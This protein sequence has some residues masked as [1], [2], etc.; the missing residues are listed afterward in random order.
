[1]FVCSLTSDRR[2]VRGV[3]SSFSRSLG[4]RG[5]ILDGGIVPNQKSVHPEKAD[6]AGRT[7]FC[8]ASFFLVEFVVCEGGLEKKGG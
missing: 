8:K 7:A 6:Q 2:D 5:G 3:S 4:W 1:M